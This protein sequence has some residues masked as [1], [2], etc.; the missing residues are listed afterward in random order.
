MKDAIG[1]AFGAAIQHAPASAA[2]RQELYGTDRTAA[3]AVMRFTLQL[4][5]LS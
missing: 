4:R 3:M 5:L 2:T 1:K